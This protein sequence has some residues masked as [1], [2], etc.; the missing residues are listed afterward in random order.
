MGKFLF[1]GT[2]A[3]MGVPVIGCRCP[4]CL[5]SSP[6]DK[7]LRA[8]GL[9]EIGSKKMLLDCGPDFRQQ[10]LAHNI[11]FLDEVIITHAHHD[12][13]ASIDELRVFSFMTKKPVSCLMSQVTSLEI[14]E[15]FKYMFNPSDIEKGTPQKL[16]IT[17]LKEKRG[18]IFIAGIEARY[19]T[20]KQAGMEVNGFRFG[21]FAYVSDIRDYEETIFEDLAGVEVLV[22]SALR[23]TPSP[24]HFT[25]DQ[26][27]DFSRRIG[28]RETWLTHLSHDL[29]HD[30]TNAYLPKEVRLAYDGLEI[31][32]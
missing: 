21:D 12:H 5:S 23:F 18:E 14:I 31:H 15:R 17:L 9:L 11:S 32:F 20:Y 6:K 10:A 3:S 26:A 8:S 25:V 4:V 29:Q 1:L 30:K 24:L 2:G 16:A 7:R 22:L 27:V 13:T 19:F 28:A